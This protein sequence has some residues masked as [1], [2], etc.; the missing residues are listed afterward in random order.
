MELAN[1]TS[2]E[3]LLSQG[4][5]KLSLKAAHRFGLS[6][7]R[8]ENG[9]SLGMRIRA[10]TAEVFLTRERLPGGTSCRPIS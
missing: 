1:A 6:N 8:A 7:L 4:R 3:M 10:G 5:F 2:L 9:K